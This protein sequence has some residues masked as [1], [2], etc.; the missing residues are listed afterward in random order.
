[1]R[2]AR[3]IRLWKMNACRIDPQPRKLRD[4]PSPV[5]IGGLPFQDDS[6]IGHLAENLCP[7][8]QYD[9]VDLA[10]VIERTE[11]DIAGLKAGRFAHRGRG[12]V[13][14]VTHKRPIETNQLFGAI[15]IG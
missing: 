6:R 10:E 15:W 7:G 12:I 4:N 1:M 9:I 8:L 14:P 2:L 5:L 3:D 11:G 13:R